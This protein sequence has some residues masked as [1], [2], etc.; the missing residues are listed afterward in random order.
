MEAADWD[1]RYAGDGLVWGGEPNRF[2]AAEL[3]ETPPGR[4][5][6]IA[7]GEGRNA[8]W[9]ATR[10]WSA[11]G[12]DFSATAIERARGLAEQTGVADSTQFVVVDVVDGQLPA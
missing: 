7:C 6:D 8:I 4:A 1:A 2:V 10:D 12:V 11:V 5:L 9:L 3:G